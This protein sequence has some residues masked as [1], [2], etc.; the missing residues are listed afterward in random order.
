[1][2]HDRAVRILAAQAGLETRWTDARG[3]KHTVGPDTLKAV[4][5]ALELPADT[6]SD[7]VQSGEALRRESESIP[8]MIVARGGQEIRVAGCREACLTAESGTRRSLRLHAQRGGGCTLR[9]PRERGYHELELD[10]AICTLAV[11]PPRCLKPQDLAGRPLAG[12]SVQ[13]YSLPYFARLG[14][15][16]LYA[17]PILAAR[18]GPPHGYDVIDHGRINPELGGEAAPRRLVSRLKD[19][20]LGI[21][22][23]IVPNHMAI[24]PPAALNGLVQ[25]VLPARARN[26]AAF[27]RSHGLS[28]AFPWQS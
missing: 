9:A 1:M 20:G 8:P 10:G 6:H 19:H 14:I 21:I 18:I 23:D 3:R 4:L 26:V 24:A 7:I 12:V 22:V 16:H 5:R 27:S 17:S 2:N 28:R 11:A 25:Y 13:I 15:R